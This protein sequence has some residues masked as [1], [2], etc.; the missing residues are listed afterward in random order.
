MARFP[1][2]PSKSPFKRPAPSGPGPMRPIEGMQQGATMRPGAGGV[3]GVAGGGH[4]SMQQRFQPMAQGDTAAPVSDDPGGAPAAG[5]IPNPEWP[6]W[7]DYHGQDDVCQ[8]CTYMA[9]DGTCPVVQQPVDPGGH[10]KAF[11]S[12]TDQEPEAAEM[13]GGAPPEAGEEEQQQ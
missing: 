7:L 9:D 13:Q 11:E 1:N 4:P 10:C 2:A 6:M 8:N 12:K 5:D 3:G